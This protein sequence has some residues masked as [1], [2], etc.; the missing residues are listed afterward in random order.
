MQQAGIELSEFTQF[1]PVEYPFLPQTGSLKQQQKITKK[2]RSLCGD[3]EV[4]FNGTGSPFSIL[5]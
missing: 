4:R 3:D 2:Y 1:S 5:H